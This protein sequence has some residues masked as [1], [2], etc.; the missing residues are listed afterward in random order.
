VR[1]V[2]AVALGSATTEARPRALAF[3]M[4]RLAPA[5]GLIGSLRSA[6]GPREDVRLLAAYAR[7]LASLD[8][9]GAPAVIERLSSTR[10]ELRPLVDAIVRRTR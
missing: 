4:A 2:A 7:A 9:A 8:P 10:A 3:V 5:Q 1:A 6:L